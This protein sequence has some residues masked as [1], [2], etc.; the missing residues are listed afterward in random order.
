MPTPA[1]TSIDEIISVGGQIIESDGLD[2]LTMQKVAVVVGVRTPSLYKHVSG[3]GELVKLIIEEVVK[4]LA[5]SLEIVARG[6][7]PRRDLIALANAFREFAQRQPGS[8]QLLF[9]PLPDEMRPSTETLAQASD[10]V[11]RACA[12]LAGDDRALDSARLITAWGHGF[13]TME[14]AGAFRLDGDLDQAF[15]YGVERLVAAID[16]Y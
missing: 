9:A 15:T 13:V 1:R 16:S 14:L 8:Y 10:P 7:D 12:A 11:V 2:G 4:A 6:D 3:R 5:R